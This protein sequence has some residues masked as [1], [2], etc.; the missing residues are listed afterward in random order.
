M[1]LKTSLPLA[2]A[3]GL[4]ASSA[5]AQSNNPPPNRDR[6]MIDR[7]ARMHD[8]ARMHRDRYADRRMAMDRGRSWRMTRWCHS[9]PWRRMMRNPRCRWLMHQ[10]HSDRM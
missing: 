6:A 7:G 9:M 5:A 2:V 4:M 1:N 8:E 3:L 10:R